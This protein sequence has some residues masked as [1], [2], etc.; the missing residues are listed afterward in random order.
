MCILGLQ[1][2]SLGFG[3]HIWDVAPANFTPMWK[4]LFVIQV[5][6]HIAL[7]LARASTICFFQRIFAVRTQ[8][9]F[10]AAR[11]AHTLNLIC[12]LGN[13]GFTFGRCSP[14]AKNWNT[15]LPGHCVLMEAYMIVG[16]A[17]SVVNDLL[18]L[19]IPIPPLWSL[20][21]TRNRKLLIYLLFFVG[22]G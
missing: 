21:L 3:H 2:I 15:L 11:T 18:I 13:L 17:T 1:T 20:Q 6:Y 16:L 12:S 7:V 14:F 22:Y 9:M 19:L 5:N 4:M 8:W 10:Y